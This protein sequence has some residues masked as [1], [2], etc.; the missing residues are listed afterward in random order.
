MNFK[1]NLIYYSL[2]AIISFILSFVAF[3]AGYYFGQGTSDPDYY[4]SIGYLGFLLL[5][6]ISFIFVILTFSNFIALKNTK[7]FKDLSIF[8][9]LRQDEE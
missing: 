3:K 7:S 6:L 1:K 4:E 9:K 5:N 8:K 2:L